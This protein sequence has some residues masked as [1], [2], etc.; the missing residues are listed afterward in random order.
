MR[1]NSE[2]VVIV[3]GGQAGV[4]TALSL[5]RLK[6]L[7]DIVLLDGEAEL[8]YERPPLSKGI[9]L[10]KTDA[11]RIRFRPPN[12]YE[13]LGIKLIAHRAV[14]LDSG[15]QQVAI[16]NGMNMKYQALVLATGAKPRQLSVPGNTLSGILAL[17]TL[18]D[19]LDLK[20]ALVPGAR[21]A[22]VG[23]GYLGLEIAAAATQI[24]ARVTIIEAGT[25]LLQR[26]GSLLL[27]DI[28][29]KRL[30][31]AGVRI[32]LSESVA[33]FRGETFVEA[34]ETTNGQ[35]FE[36]DVVLV[37][38]G[39]APDVDLMREV[40][41][42]DPAGILVD[43]GARTAMPNVYAVGD[44]ANF[45]DPRFGRHVRLESVQSAT[46]QAKVA[47]AGI[48][49]T[50]PPNPKHAYFWSEL[51]DLKIQ[52]AGF[53]DPAAASREE[54]IGTKDHGFAVYR[55]Q[56]DRLAAVEC[57]NRPAEFVKAQSLIG[58]EARSLINLK[59]V[60]FEG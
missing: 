16:S 60:S 24:G 26:S 15:R 38:V 31:E 3:G 22:V 5:R 43:A 2:P 58:R 57:I 33:R 20:A 56:H 13:E 21:L 28:L 12:L 11:G 7:G 51:F 55:F 48:T 47:A 6:Q 44:C 29:T 36:A 19:S 32:A 52:I 18:A 53:V 23:G 42:Y 27:S 45:H 50:M 30:G 59:E 1:S 37:A 41:L 17:R 39:A 49:G 4:E 8:P 40:G 14:S 25:R 35:V 54:L 10:S 9:L 34:V 46:W